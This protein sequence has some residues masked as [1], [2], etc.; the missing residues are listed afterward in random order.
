[1]DAA[2]HAADT[3]LSLAR[4][5]S[6]TLQL[7]ADDSWHGLYNL[8]KV[9]R[10]TAALVLHHDAITG[11]SRRT[12]AADYESR[13]RQAITD[14]HR[15][16]ATVGAAYMAADRTDTSGVSSFMSAGCV[17]CRGVAHDHAS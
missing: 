13:L 9:S 14:C 5:T 7:P 11:T 10:H 1:M 12:V 16:I 17:F 6:R 15:V 2:L 4:T 3:L 8:V